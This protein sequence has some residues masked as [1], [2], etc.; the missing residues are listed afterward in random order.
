MPEQG[1][2]GT[3]DELTVRGIECL[4]HHGVF[5]FERIEGQVFVV[6]L[7]LGL[8]TQPAAT[9]DDLRDTVDYGSLVA[10]VKAAVETDPVDL[11][12]T[13]AQRVADVCLLDDRVGYAKVTIHKPT[14]PIQATFADVALTITRKR[15]G[16]P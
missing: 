11:I 6:D 3:P 7:A 16:R 1:P 10:Q 5:E 14:A 15:E 9:S 12:E 2:P 13:L 4:G 8:D